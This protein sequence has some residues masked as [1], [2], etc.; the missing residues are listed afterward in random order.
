MRGCMA[1]LAA[2]CAAQLACA[3]D[4]A[5]PSRTVQIVVPYTPGTGADILARILGPR[6]AERW[7]TAVVTDNRPGA[8]GNIG[9]DFVAKAV[10]DGHTLLFTATSFATTPALSGKLPFDPVKSFAPVSLLA[11]SAMSLVVH[12]QLPVKSLQ[13]FIGLARRQPGK[14]LYSSPGNGGPQHL[15]M[16]LIKLETKTDLVHVPYKGSGGA[17]T[18]LMGGHVQAMVVALQTAGPFVQSGRLRMLAILGA[19]RSPAFPGVLT[20]KEQGLANLEV[21]PW[22]GVFAP[23]AAPP[24]VVS[25]INADLHALLQLPDIRDQLAK[26]GM[27]AAGGAPERFANLVKSELARWARVVQAAKIKSD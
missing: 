21:E 1:L 17:L 8:T 20:L 7:K 15:T 9:T 3:Q 26:Q 16:E 23:A 25:K 12:P 11:T 6:L 2:L 22:Y 24:A 19:E 4:A 27:N 10:P 18:D 13:D 14:L 5:F